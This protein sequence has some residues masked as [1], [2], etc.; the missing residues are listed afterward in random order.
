MI[1]SRYVRTAQ[2]GYVGQSI[3]AVSIVNLET[4]EKAFA[5]TS[6]LDDHSPRQPSNCWNALLSYRFVDI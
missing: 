3:R 2:I 1:V 6:E 4:V 5:Q